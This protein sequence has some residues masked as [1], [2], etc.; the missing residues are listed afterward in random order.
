MNEHELSVIPVE[1]RPFQGVTAGVATRLVANTID[2]L[3]VWATML[4]GYVGFAA[5]LFFFNPRTFTFPDFSP[6]LSVL[7]FLAVSVVY[8]TGAWWINGQTFGDRVMGMRVVS[9]SPA[10]APP[11]ARIHA[12]GVLR[13]LPDRPDVVRGQPEAPVRAGPGAVD[14]RHLRLEPAGDRARPGRSVG[15]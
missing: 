10:A 6:V 11:R 1:A 7:W 5:V 9:R 13:V 8:L 2:T 15:E 3:V 12:R 14:V 4:G